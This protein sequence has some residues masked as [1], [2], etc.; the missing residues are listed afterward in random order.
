VI[1][2]VAGQTHTSAEQVKNGWEYIKAQ[3]SDLQ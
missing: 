3:V 2:F 1:R